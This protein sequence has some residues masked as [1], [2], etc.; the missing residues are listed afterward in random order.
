MISCYLYLLMCLTDYNEAHSF[1]E[2]LGFG[3]L[4]A[5]FLTV[6][7]NV[8]NTVGLL[9]GVCCRR[10]ARRFGKRSRIYVKEPVKDDIQT[11]QK[12]NLKDSETEESKDFGQ[13]GTSSLENLTKFRDT[14]PQRLDLANDF[15]VS[16]PLKREN[17][18]TQRDL[19]L[20][21]KIEA[22]VL[23]DLSYRIALSTEPQLN[24][25]TAKR[26]K[27]VNVESETDD[28]SQYRKSKIVKI[29]NLSSEKQVLQNIWSQVEDK[30][31]DRGE[32]KG[33]NIWQ[34]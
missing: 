8:A 20:L 21:N 9:M 28:E 17:F 18:H 11:P 2:E 29:D 30:K 19:E 31:I 5:V 34:K 14:L 10:V 32:G 24:R 3:L 23:R 6:L 25:A 15:F 26:I 22:R 4:G 13:T 33:T 1:R 12:V 16:Q 7:V 27:A